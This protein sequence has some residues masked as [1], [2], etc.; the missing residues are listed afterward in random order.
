ML[1]LSLGF[2]RGYGRLLSQMLI[3]RLSQTFGLPVAMRLNEIS[4][5][6]LTLQY[7]LTS[8]QKSGQGVTSI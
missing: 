3:Y 1:T 6:S 4:D 8:S 2:D 5:V 7:V